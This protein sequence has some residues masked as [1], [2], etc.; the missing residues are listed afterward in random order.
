[1]LLKENRVCLQL[2]CPNPKY[3]P[4]ASMWETRQRQGD[5]AEAGR[6]CMAYPEQP[7][8]TVFTES[9]ERNDGSPRWLMVCLTLM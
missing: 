5:Q 4:Q 7:D 2:E 6:F 1:M 8:G 3:V 9:N